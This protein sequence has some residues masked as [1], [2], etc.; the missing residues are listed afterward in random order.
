M[1]KKLKYYGIIVEVEENAVVS[2]NSWRAFLLNAWNYRGKEGVSPQA[3]FHKDNGKEFQ[4]Y[5]FIDNGSNFGW[6]RNQSTM[7]DNNNTK[8]NVLPALIDAAA[9]N[10]HV[11]EYLEE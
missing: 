1:S 9:I 7:N 5:T 8:I 3:F 10:N 4:S 11:L 2:N 6:L